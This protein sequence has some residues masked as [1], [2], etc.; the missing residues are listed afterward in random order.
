MQFFIEAHHSLL[1][2]VIDETRIQVFDETPKGDANN[3]AEQ[4]AEYERDAEE[5]AG[6]RFLSDDPGV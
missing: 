4:V 3:E 1:L 5:H 6:I 2:D